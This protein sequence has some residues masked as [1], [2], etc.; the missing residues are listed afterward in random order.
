MSTWLGFLGVAL[1][2]ACNARAYHDRLWVHISGASM[3]IY[4]LALWRWPF[5]RSKKPFQPETPWQ[6]MFHAF[7]IS[8]GIYQFELSPFAMLTGVLLRL[9]TLLALLSLLRARPIAR[10]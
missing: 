9:A 7:W 10:D 5:L 2:V 3:V 4:A 8:G 1:L 6:G